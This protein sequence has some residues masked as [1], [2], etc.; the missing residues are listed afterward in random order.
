MIE[1]GLRFALELRDYALGQ[2][3][4]EF[5]SPLVERV[6][7]PNDA[8]RKNGMFVKGQEL[9]Q[10]FLSELVGKIAL[11]YAALFLIAWSKMVGFDVSPLTDKSS[12]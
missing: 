5:N 7:I 4:A 6:E 9:T 1:I 11:S 2:H 12:M 8:L 3:L 10:C